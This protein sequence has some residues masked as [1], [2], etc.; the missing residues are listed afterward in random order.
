[1]IRDCRTERSVPQAGKSLEPRE[2]MAKGFHCSDMSKDLQFFDMSG[3]KVD[4]IDMS[5]GHDEK[6]P[7]NRHDPKADA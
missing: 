7:K 5:R 6:G 3:P 2:A 1:M 4:R